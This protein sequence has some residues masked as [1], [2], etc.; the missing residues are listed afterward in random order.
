MASIAVTDVC[1]ALSVESG[2]RPAQSCLPSRD[3][4]CATSVRT[5]EDWSR[6]SSRSLRAAS[7]ES[8]EVPN[9]RA[10]SM[11]SC[12][13]AERDAASRTPP[14]AEAPARSVSITS[15][16]GHANVVSLHERGPP[17]PTESAAMARSGASAGSGEPCVRAPRA[18]AST[19]LA[20]PAAT[21]ASLVVVIRCT[22]R[23]FTL[24]RP[25]SSRYGSLPSAWAIDA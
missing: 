6:A 15:R 12:E 1:G 10:A 18:S 2:R 5:I 14:V 23:R 21:V 13:S 17:T 9:P 3:H 25:A 8:L 4:A 11:R 20:A 7:I 16:L 24:A 19:P 22:S